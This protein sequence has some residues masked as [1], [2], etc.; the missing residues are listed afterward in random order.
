MELVVRPVGASLGDA[1]NALGGV[2]D[3]LQGRRLNLDLSYLGELAD[4]FLFDDDTQICH[5]IYREEPGQLATAS[6]SGSCDEPTG[7]H[8]V[9]G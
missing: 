8:I 1:T 6:G 5:V 2:A 7:S 4:A 3:T 9:A